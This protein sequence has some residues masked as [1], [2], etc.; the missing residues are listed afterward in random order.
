MAQWSSW[1]ALSAHAVNTCPGARRCRAKSAAGPSSATRAGDCRSMLFAASNVASVSIARFRLR[2][3]EAGSTAGTAKSVASRSCR[4]AATP[5]IARR[6][7]NKKPTA[8]PTG[9]PSRDRVVASRDSRSILDRSFNATIA[10]FAARGFHGTAQMLEEIHETT[11]GKV[12][13]AFPRWSRRGVP[14]SAVVLEALALELLLKVKLAQAGR[15]VP[16]SHDHSRLYADLPAAGE[17]R[18]NGNIKSADINLC[19]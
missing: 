12:V 10:L 16:K 19:L 9:S 1:S 7:A 6:R 2:G 13:E 4:S 8:K 11:F 5:G 14:I 18:R 3:T 17:R 15:P